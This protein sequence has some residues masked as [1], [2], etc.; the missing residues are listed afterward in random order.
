MAA[1]LAL[2]AAPFAQLVGPTST[3]SGITVAALENFD[4]SGSRCF[5][6]GVDGDLISYSVPSGTATTVIPWSTGYAGTGITT[7][8]SPNN[9]AIFSAMRIN[10]NDPCT[11]YVSANDPQVPGT[12]AP[13]G[14]KGGLLIF[15][16]CG[17]PS[18]IAYIDLST[19]APQPG[20]PT[21]VCDVVAWNGKIVVNLFLASKVIVMDADGSNAA[22]RPLVATALAA[23]NCNPNGM[24]VTADGQYVLMSCFWFGSPAP[25]PP[26]SSLMRWNPATDAIAPVV[27]TGDSP[28]QIDDIHFNP[29]GDTLYVA[30][31]ALAGSPMANSATAMTTTDNWATATV[32]ATYPAGCSGSM[33]AVSFVGSD[34]YG[35]CFADPILYKFNIAAPSG[36]ATKDPHFHFAHGGRA[37][38]RGQHGAVYNLLS[39][40]NVTMNVK[41]ENADFSWSKRTVHGTK[42]SAAYW[43]ITNSDNK[44]VQIAMDAHNKTELGHKG[45]RGHVT[46]EGKQYEVTDSTPFVAGNVR[47][48]LT[49]NKLIVT[50]TQWEMTAKVASFPFATLNKGKVLLDVSLKPLYNVEADVVAPHG[51]VGQSFD[52]D[53]FD[54]D[55]AM[56]KSKDAVTTTTAQGEGAIEGVIADYKVATSFATEF[57]YS[58]F[59]KLAAKP[60]DTT[61]LTGIRKSKKAATAAGASAPSDM[62]EA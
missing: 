25:Q 51:I 58:R 1:L 8:A 7:Q 53:D 22:E 21:V 34:M 45:H 55:G 3:P 47:A 14:P 41:F 29:S 39:H 36:G 10:R 17:T 33:A 30:V 61:K 13:L 56:D 35:I 24:E 6:K 62:V 46:F 60:R 28:A 12:Q 18:V 48:S 20:P 44:V 5:G 15:N 19:F 40:K 32:T 16:I 37:D 9:N 26:V 2:V 57:A 11:G 31:G 27:F 38:I 43:S 4:C 54:F 49:S 50:N 23:N 59:G 52:G 42:L